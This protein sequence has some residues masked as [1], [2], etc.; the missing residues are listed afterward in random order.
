MSIA[1]ITCNL[2]FFLL[3]VSLQA[4]QTA[5]YRI[6]L[7][8]PKMQDSVLYLGRYQG[9][10]TYL[11][12]TAYKQAN[13]NVFV[14]EGQHLPPTGLY[15]IANNA[16]KNLIDLIIS[17][18]S[19]HFTLKATK[20]FDV[21]D[22]KYVHSKENKGLHS[23]LKLAAQNYAYVV[24]L[25]ARL[26]ILKNQN[27]DSVA[28]I[29]AEM[30]QRHTA[31]LAYR[32]K[33]LKQ[34]PTGY[35]PILFHLLD[36][37]EDNQTYIDASTDKQ[38]NLDTLQWY[39]LRKQHYWD[40]IDLKNDNVLYNPFIG[41]KIENYFDNYVLFFDIDSLTTEIDNF[42][43][44]LL[45]NSDMYMYSLWLLLNKYERSEIMGHDAVLVHMA[46]TY[47]THPGKKIHKI[48][49]QNIVKKANARRPIL[50]GHVAPE[51]R[52]KDS[53]LRQH[54]LSE[55]QARFTILAFWNPAC[56]HCEEEMPL[57]LEYYKKN[58]AKYNL[59]VIGVC[60]TPDFK[61]FTSKL[62]EWKPDFLNILPMTERFSDPDYNYME[63]YQ[64]DGTPLLFL[65]DKDKRIIAKDFG[66]Q[67]IDMLIE[68]YLQRQK[69]H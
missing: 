60:S 67:H 37:V 20:G 16:K 18:Q 21:K 27:S 29:K 34:Y 49:A 66:V 69:N 17:E 57:L 54:A 35:L 59:E 50:I 36:N 51:L 3:F 19:H 7:Q 64:V 26:P 48:I 47:F 63:T 56:Y 12:D 40:N 53:T 4:Q 30:K 11:I 14:F 44:S 6:E 13:T 32:Q 41:G 55:I 43:N 52:G 23:Y 15:F 68:D 1:K 45:P 22:I 24:P 65:L 9:H 58:K 33:L 46:D 31:E 39:N 10:K 25:Q 5:A 38:G 61:G 28:I 8:T 62:K 2:S 42:M